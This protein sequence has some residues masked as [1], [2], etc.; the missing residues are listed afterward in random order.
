MTAP[1]ATMAASATGSAL[2]ASLPAASFPSAA[3]FSTAAT[4]A[5]ARALI[6]APSAGSAAA[7]LATA[8]VT[9]A[10]A[11]AAI[12]LQ[13][14]DRRLARLVPH[15]V[16][17]GGGV[18]GERGE[19]P[20]EHALPKVDA[21]G[22]LPVGLSPR[23]AHEP[24]HRRGLEALELV[25]RPSLVAEADEHSRHAREERLQPVLEELV[26]LEALLSTAGATAGG[27]QVD[28]VCMSTHCSSSLAAATAPTPTAAAAAAAATT[29]TAA[30]TVSS[31]RGDACR[32][33]VFSSTYLLSPARSS[34]RAELCR[35]A[36][37]PP[38]LYPHTPPLGRRH[39][40]W[41]R[42]R[43]RPP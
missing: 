10:A 15:D 6:S 38:R 20:L 22:G 12:A 24:V 5:S 35:D 19:Q 26:P 37:P 13:Q 4:L 31:S 33:L 11:A 17:R 2:A 23:A 41:R 7:A 25:H 30:T 39:R 40:R 8:A 34:R 32:L 3:T 36:L 9:A 16:V 1:A 29:A 43:S 28:G 18:G 27:R 42:S 14:E 21:G